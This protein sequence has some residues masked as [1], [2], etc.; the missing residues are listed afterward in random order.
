MQF[1][2]D[3]H[4]LL[5]APVQLR[6]EL[7]PDLI[8]PQQKQHHDAGR[9]NQ[10]DRR[11][12]QQDGSPPDRLTHFFG[13]DF[14]DQIPGGAWHRTQRRKNRHAP[15]VHS[16]HIPLTALHRHNRGHV[17]PAD[18]NPQAKRAASV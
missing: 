17:A 18:R 14:S 1:P 5:H 13:V 3:P 11:D 2:R 10:R 15:V 16:L 4:A 6:V 7:P 9:Q 12:P 8:S